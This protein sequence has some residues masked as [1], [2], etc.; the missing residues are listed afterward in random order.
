MKN[1]HKNID[2]NTH[3]AFLVVLQKCLLEC[4]ITKD[5]R[6]VPK[7]QAGATSL[8]LYQRMKN[9]SGLGGE[10]MFNL[11]DF[12]K[13]ED[14][15]RVQ[16]YGRRHVQR[17]FGLSHGSESMNGNISQVSRRS[18]RQRNRSSKP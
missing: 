9:S 5:R 1:C 3:V 10:L 14:V 6:S 2:R 11:E 8:E 15:S 17:K 18:P 7:G 4:L 16:K 13:C 12:D